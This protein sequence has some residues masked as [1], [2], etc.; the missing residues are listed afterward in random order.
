MDLWIPCELLD[1][2]NARGG[3]VKLYRPAISYISIC[4][5]LVDPICAEKEPHLSR[6]YE[7][8]A[9]QMFVEADEKS[10]I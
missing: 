6:I 9:Q 8:R 2:L 4:W 10:E 3:P 5:G 7:I 1:P